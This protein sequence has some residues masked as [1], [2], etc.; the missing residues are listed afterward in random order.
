ME[1]P[2]RVLTWNVLAERWIEPDEV[3]TERWARFAR[4]CHW[5]DALDADVVALQEVEPEEYALLE[6]RMRVRG[7]RCDYGHV[8]AAARRFA[9]AQAS[10]LVR[11]LWYDDAARSTSGHT[12]FCR[13][14][15]ARAVA[16]VSVHLDDESAARRLAQLD[17]C[18]A[19][20]DPARPRIV[21]GDFNEHYD[22]ARGGG[23]LYA[24]ARRRGMTVCV[25]GG[26][27]TYY[28]ELPARAYA[29]DNVLVAGVAGV[30]G[31]HVPPAPPDAARGLAEYG[32]DHLP[33]VVD[34]LPAARE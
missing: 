6:A 24:L 34:F 23:A 19:A 32:S 8:R 28:T 2:L 14:R 13:E 21:A 15:V 29:I 30:P 11:D 18:L 27:S 4:V 20:L 7:Y 1:P 33:V 3:R 10:D 17:A 26:A 5:L 31:A 9:G 16:V 25:T 22:T 12:V